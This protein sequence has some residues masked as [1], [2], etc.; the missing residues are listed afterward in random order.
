MSLKKIPKNC[1]NLVKMN[2]NGFISHK[3]S[4][5]THLIV[6]NNRKKTFTKVFDVITQDKAFGN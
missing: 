3:N 2:I 1:I 6:Y 5:L 4:I